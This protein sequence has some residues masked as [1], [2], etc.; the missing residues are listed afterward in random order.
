MTQNL[1]SKRLQYRHKFQQFLGSEHA[2]AAAEILFIYLENT[3]DNAYDRQ[4]YDWS[5]TC[6]PSTSINGF[7][8]LF[9]VNIS[10]MEVFV[11]GYY[12]DEPE[13]LRAFINVSKSV[14][15]NYQ[16]QFAKEYPGLSFIEADYVAANGD[17]LHIDDMTGSE[18]IQDVIVDDRVSEAATVLNQAL[19][20]HS[21]I[22]ARYHNFD[23]V[24]LA[25]AVESS[26]ESLDEPEEIDP[27]AINLGSIVVIQESG[28]DPE[29]YSI[30]EADDADP[31]Q[32]KLSI[33][34]P[35][36]QALLG[37]YAGDQITVEVPEGEL[38]LEILEVRQPDEA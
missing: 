13:V 4:F 16:E 34:S 26:P 15:Q 21:N 28:N 9:C 8:R 6:L 17:A 31:Q 5:V 7:R 3:I 12:R 1:W 35:V 32:G 2:D 25:Y 37:Q 27:D 14:F 36:G 18:M 11:V 19:L 33:D 38:T 30:V 22:Y 23:L 20:Q 29:T 24:D 10:R